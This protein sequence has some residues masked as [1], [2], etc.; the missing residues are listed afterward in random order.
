M[1]IDNYG[2][3]NILLKQENDFSLMRIEDDF[4]TIFFN[5]KGQL[6]EEV[7]SLVEHQGLYFKE[8]TEPTNFSPQLIH[9]RKLSISLDQLKSVSDRKLPKLRVSRKKGQVLAY[10]AK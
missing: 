8:L 5:L 2:S 10:A 6:R 4:N 3:L 9:I 1:V 7:E